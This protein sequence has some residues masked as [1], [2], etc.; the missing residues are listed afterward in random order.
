MSHLMDLDEYDEAA[1]RAELKQRSDARAQG[2][3]DYCKRPWS[4]KPCRFRARHQAVKRDLEAVKEGTAVE[5]EPPIIDDATAAAV[6]AIA[7]RY[8]M[9]WHDVIGTAVRLYVDKHQQV[10]AAGQAVLEHAA[11]QPDEQQWPPPLEIT[12]GQWRALEYALAY[13]LAQPHERP[14]RASLEIEN[15]T[16]ELAAVGEYMEIV[17]HEYVLTPKG[18]AWAALAT[19]TGGAFADE[20]PAVGRRVRVT[21]EG[22]RDRVGS[23]APLDSIGTLA[24]VVPWEPRFY[25]YPHGWAAGVEVLEEPGKGWSEADRKRPGPGLES[26][27]AKAKTALAAVGVPPGSIVEMANVAARMLE[28]H[29]VALDHREASG[30]GDGT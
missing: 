3:C 6:L 8:G 30:E 5:G 18:R 26:D 2:L 14:A 17:R 4:E 15:A 29:P 28:G 11:R 19:K 25:V 22:P 12:A 24:Q 10:E 27:V 21:K 13:E 1:L 16:S 23:P 20:Q 7:E 9:P